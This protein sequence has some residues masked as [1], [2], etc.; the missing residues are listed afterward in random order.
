MHTPRIL[1][2]RQAADLIHDGDTITV[3]S[4][5][6][7]GCP[8][9]VLAGI[10]TRFD[11]TRS[12]AGITSVHSIAAGDMWGIKGIDHLARPGLLRRVVAGSYPSGPSSAD[13]PAIWQMIENNE[14]EAYN[15]PSGILFQLHRAA[16]AKQPGVLSQVGIDTFV[17]PRV[18]AGRMNTITPNAYVRV[19]EIDDQEWLFYEALVPDVAVIRATTADTHGNLT[20]EEEAS[21]LGALDLAY[22]AHNNG[23][24][25]IA[26][27]KYLAEGGSLAPQAVRVPGILVDAIVVVPD[28]LQTTQTPYD[29]AI[30][31]ELRR[32]LSTLDP[33]PFSLEKIMARRAAAELRSG[34]I[35][36]IGFGVSALVPHVLVEEGLPQAVSWVIEQGA[37]GGVPL[38]DFVFGVSQNPDAIMQSSDQ[39]TLLQGG[40][41]E[42]SLLSF[43]EIDRH[44]NVNVHSLPKR[45]HVTAGLGGFVD[46]T[47]GAPSIV[48]V[49][50]FTAGRR[51]IGIGNGR[52]DIRAD[53]PHTK[54]VADV[55]SPTF[56]GRRAIEKGQRVLYVTERAVLELRPAG[57]TVVEIAPGVDLQRD[58]LDR[59]E[60]ELLVDP[61]LRTM[62]SGLFSP[63]RM[64]LTLDLQ[65]AHSRIR[66]LD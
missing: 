53:G 33:V 18:G 19:Q 42:H 38:L 2:A 44:G 11:E 40:G 25:V 3:S 58:V 36:N 1:T 50:S 10:G 55:D 45:R 7:L 4:S 59:S 29:P 12:P 37:V 27:V 47:T 9:A 51:D 15:L 21:P 20:F 48:F 16:A 49:G 5:S 56:S 23:G 22:A 34:E 31:G 62:A 13:P 26:Q 8:D 57:I 66:A 60:F 28:Q 41:F 64:G 52:L 39:F 61:D 14:V 17:D 30:S 32:P 35:A 43:L 6:G 24:V 65:P 63:D 46:I 54:L